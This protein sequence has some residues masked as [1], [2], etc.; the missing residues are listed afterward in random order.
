MEYTDCCLV[1]SERVYHT[2]P[3]SGEGTEGANYDET[4]YGYDVRKRRNR[5]V[6]PGGTITRTVID[7][8]SLVT[9]VWIGIDDFGGTANLSPAGATAF[10]PDAGA[11]GGS[12]R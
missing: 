2:I 4:V 6:T 3:A 5:T 8:R 12:S 1:E 9:S 10:R 11:H 7:V